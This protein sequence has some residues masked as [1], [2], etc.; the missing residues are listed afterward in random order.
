MI[1][2]MILNKILLLMKD[3]G[4]LVFEHQYEQINLLFEL[5]CAL[6]LLL[7][8]RWFWLRLESSIMTTSLRKEMEIPLFLKHEALLVEVD[9][10]RIIKM[11]Q[12]MELHESSKRKI[13]CAKLSANLIR[14]RR[15]NEKVWQIHR[16]YISRNRAHFNEA[17]KKQIFSSKTVLKI[18]D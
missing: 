14:S 3:L 7:K 8:I 9:M 18:S 12:R 4:I 16:M 10:L 2:L 11:L 17:I 6:I 5:N 13:T 15:K 1:L